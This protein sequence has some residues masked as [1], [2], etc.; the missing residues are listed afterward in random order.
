MGDAK[1]ARQFAFLSLSGVGV[2]ALA[3]DRATFAVAAFAE[4]SEAT[5]YRTAEAAAAAKTAGL[6][7]VGAE[8]KAYVA[9]VMAAEA[10]AGAAGTVGFPAL[11][12][13]AAQAVAAAAASAAASAAARAAA[14]A[15][16]DVRRCGP[17]VGAAAFDATLC[18]NDQAPKGALAAAAA[19]AEAAAE[20]AAAA[21]ERDTRRRPSQ[22][23]LRPPPSATAAGVGL[24]HA[25]AA[26]GDSEAQLALAHRY[27]VTHCSS[28]RTAVKFLFVGGVSGL[29]F[30]PNLC[31]RSL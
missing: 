16:V 29:L 27:Q 23:W 18:A 7:A 28:L 13:V 6:V 22:L 14:A 25:A 19:F 8:E 17:A 2:G 21:Q 12:A 24:L 31:V 4:L 30:G 3:D 1:S 20:A 26:M 15:L 10:A 9:A 11:P 5:N